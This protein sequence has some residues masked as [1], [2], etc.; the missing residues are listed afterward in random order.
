MTSRAEDTNT[1]YQL[2]LSDGHKYL[3]YKRKLQ[4]SAGRQTSDEVKLLPVYSPEQ[5]LKVFNFQL[6]GQLSAV[7]FCSTGK[8]SIWC[9]CTTLNI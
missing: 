5:K 8:L 7:T 3:C 4:N 6:V 1:P 9:S 2:T